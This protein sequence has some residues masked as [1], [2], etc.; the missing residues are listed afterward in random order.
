MLHRGFDR[1][2]QM[3]TIHA[4]NVEEALPLALNMLWDSGQPV[5]SRGLPT[6]EA[7]GPVAT[8]YACPW[9][10]VLV[11]PV[12]DA[13]PFF[14]FFESVWILA[15]ANTAN[16]PQFFL[17]RITDYS[18]DGKVFHGAYGHRLRE[19]HGFDQLK[20]AVNILKAKPDTRQ[21]V[22]SI[23]H[24]KLDLGASTKDTPCNDMIMFKI[25]DER[26]VMT[27]C[28]RSNDAIWGAYGANAVQ[29]SIIQEWVAARLGILPGRYVQM[30]DSFHVYTDLP[31]WKQ[32][33]E[34]T[35]RPTPAVNFYDDTQ[36][37]ERPLFHDPQDAA[38]AMEDAE[39][40]NQFAEMDMLPSVA[41]TA[42]AGLKSYMMKGVGVP[43]LVAYLNF[44]AGDWAGAFQAC[45][46]IKEPDWAHACHQ[47]INRRYAK[48]QK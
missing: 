26:L 8:V 40:V 9:E 20:E 23:W 30:S 14:H 32:F 3:N 7:P 22:L 13:N 45:Q 34:R 10:R 4:R 25:R 5:T 37:A 18:D 31:L 48:A 19:A 17:S 42:R 29:F 46:H 27:V 21:V 33:A 24:P 44:K 2:W 41:T 38:W 39:M 47:W 6:L 11:D 36:V 16:L 43:M 15:G 12:R 35:W 28:N 1:Q